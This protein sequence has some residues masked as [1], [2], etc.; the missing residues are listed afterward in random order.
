[1]PR[2]RT[3]PA[4]REIVLDISTLDPA[5]W[6]QGYDIDPVAFDQLTVV[7]GAITCSN[8]TYGPNNLANNG[9]YH[10]C[11][12]HDFGSGW[13]DDIEVEVN[14]LFRRPMEASPLLSV[15]T[16]DSDFGA[17]MWE[18]NDL[19]WGPPV[20]PIWLC[21]FIGSSN[22][23]F[24]TDATTRVLT[25]DEHLMYSSSWRPHPQTQMVIRKTGGFYTF[26]LNGEWLPGLKMPVPPAL[27][28][29]T[30]HGFC[31]DGNQLDFTG[32]AG[33]YRPPNWP[34]IAANTFIL[35]KL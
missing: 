12:F 16:T 26:K 15:V 24:R 20:T 7:N 4:N 14:Y 2:R 34:A 1:M 32:G 25:A 19:I 22:A 29:S 23:T 10:G 28:S 11:A 18:G 30:T 6:T 5:F 9:A 13:A 31:I 35:R 21:G 17:G 33:G 3:K 8:P 27:A